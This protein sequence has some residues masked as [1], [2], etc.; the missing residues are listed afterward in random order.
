MEL[1]F[2]GTGSGVPSKMR[3]V[4]SL[5]L[6]ML[7]ERDE[8]WLFD[9]GEATQ[10]QILHTTIKPRKIAKIFITH[11]HGD[12]IFGLPGLLSSR[13]FQDGTKPLDIYGPP[14]VKT[15]ID[16]ALIMSDTHIK[17]PIN[18]HPIKEGNIFEDNQLTVKAKKLKHGIPSYGF[19]I[20]QYDSIG[21]LQPEKLK[22]LGVEP[23][24][25]FKKIK[26]NEQ[27]T[28]QDGTVI[29][30][31]DVT[32]PPIQGKKIAILGDTRFDESVI[33]FVKH[34]DVFVHEGTFRKDDQQL[35]EN[36]FHSTSE[37][38]AIIAK[39]AEVKQ[40]ILNHISSRYQPK[41]LDQ[42]LQYLK[43]IFSHVTFA[44]DF[45]TYTV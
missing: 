41:D 25:I 14:E 30:R 43:T 9:C 2:L 7:Q 45:S 23:G 15:F 36:Y 5:A 13:S 8:V 10:H 20:E 34:A 28:L 31:D 29:N 39:K 40:L 26:E 3:N 33:P 27:V 17:Y 22:A 24:P 19:M 21:P 18:Y 6:S 42:E 44:S 35:A 1:T 12:H 11:A 32:G 37:Q 38:A 16:T 4:S